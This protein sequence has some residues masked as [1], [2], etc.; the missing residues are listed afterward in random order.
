[1][2]Q[3]ASKNVPIKTSNVIYRLIEDLQDEISD[4]L[5]CKDVEEILGELKWLV[6]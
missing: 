5:P 2:K 4:N 1:M 6:K 3:A